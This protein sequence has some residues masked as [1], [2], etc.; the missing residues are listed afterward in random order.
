MLVSAAD[1][2]QNPNQIEP[3]CRI[4]V[5]IYLKV[6]HQETDCG[7]EK[8]QKISHWLYN[9]ASHLHTLKKV[10]HSSWERNDLDS[11][12]FAAHRS[13]TPKPSWPSLNKETMEETKQL[14]W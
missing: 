4:L 8:S 5:G 2:H 6:L 7:A 9:S 14:F 12:L 13:I 3:L 10:G 1:L 11:S